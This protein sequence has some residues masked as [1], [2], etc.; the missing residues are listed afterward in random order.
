MNL[1]VW[2]NETGR[3]KSKYSTEICTDAT[4][5]PT[6]LTETR[7]ELSLSLHGEK[8]TNKLVTTC[9]KPFLEYKRLYKLRFNYKSWPLQTQWSDILG[10]EGRQYHDYGLFRMGRH[11]FVNLLTKLHDVTFK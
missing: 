2:R 11:L 6:N 7:L 8:P 4:S 9:A 5:S 3:E 10:S 1:K